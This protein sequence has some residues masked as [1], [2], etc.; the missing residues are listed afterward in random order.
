MS[1]AVQ[2]CVRMIAHLFGV[3]VVQGVDVQHDDGG[4]GWKLMTV[5]GQLIYS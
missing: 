1:A 5:R 3:A 2:V 4:G